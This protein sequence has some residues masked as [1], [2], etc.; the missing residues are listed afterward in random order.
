MLSLA[1]NFKK[2]KKFVQLVNKKLIRLSY[3]FGQ[4][5]SL[6]W[7]YIYGNSR[8]GTSYITR[9][10]GNQSKLSISDWG[11]GYILNDSFDKVQ[12]IDRDRLLKDIANNILDHANLSLG[13]ELDLV[14]KQAHA[15]YP[16]YR[17]LVKMF[18]E[19]ERKIFCFREPSGF[20]AS[21]K[22]KFPD[23]TIENLQDRYLRD[24]QVYE[25]VKGD[26]IEYNKSLT[27]DDYLRFLQP[28]KFDNKSIE[29]FFY[30]GKSNPEDATQE[31]W[32][33]YRRFK[34]VH[35]DNLYTS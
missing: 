25:R 2:Y 9:L 21:S 4:K 16:D 24:F 22:K 19:P 17:L 30:K 6:R 10:I 7:W 26:I 34:E 14:L 32:L 3:R 8:S 29:K 15:T 13:N 12:G 33:A 18:G 5:Q 1:S 11:L 23:Q 28:L 27:I 20:M 31:M 35:K